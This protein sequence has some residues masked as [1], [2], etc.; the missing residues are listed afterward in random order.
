VH[1]SP[2]SRFVTLCSV[3]VGRC[4]VEHPDDGAARRRVLGRVLLL[5]V[6]RNLHGR[7]GRAVGEEG[8]RGAA[9]VV[10]GG[11]AGDGV[12][13]AK[14]AVVARAAWNEQNAKL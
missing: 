3:I 1:S 8:G 9:V 4:H 7:R 12:R 6:W 11:H 10:G 13:G 14:V 2:L 5:V